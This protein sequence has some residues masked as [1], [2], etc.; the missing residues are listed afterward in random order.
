MT[1][2]KRYDHK[3]R[4]CDRT[5]ATLCIYHKSADPKTITDILRIRPDRT[6]RAG[7][8][9]ASK[10]PIRNSFWEVGTHYKGKITHSRDVRAHIDWL[11]DKLK[12]KKKEIRKLYKSG[13]EM[14]IYC[15]WESAHANGGPVLDSRVFKRLSELPIEFIFDIWF[16]IESLSEDMKKIKS[17]NR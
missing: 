3:Y 2:K 7:D 12:N 9:S 8:L 13:Y 10:K 6:L 1:P 14:R 17:R 16:D 4:H 15:F 5:Y 11:L